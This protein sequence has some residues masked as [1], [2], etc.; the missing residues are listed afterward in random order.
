M[1]QMP[2]IYKITNLITNQE[3]IGKTKK[4]IERRLQQYKLNIRYK[5]SKN[6]HLSKAM[7]K[8]GTF[9]F[10]IECLEEVSDDNIDK[11]EKEYI[12]KLKPHYNMTI[13]GEG[14]DTSKSLN[15]IEAMKKHH[16][17]RSRESYASYG[18]LGK[19]QSERNLQAI[20]LSNR[21]PVMCDGTRYESVG[22]AEKHYPGI[23]VRGRLDSPKYPTFY[24]LRERTRRK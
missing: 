11:K 12:A 16:A 4:P 10:I 18:M 14:G 9:N 20:K 17:S 3:Y 22:E 8:Y 24:R 13:G 19:K 6:T 2:Y 15:F 5:R 1:T 21:C 7:R 23:K